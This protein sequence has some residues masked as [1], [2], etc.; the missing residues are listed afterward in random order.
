MAWLARLNADPLPWLLA[1]DTPAV[2][3]V[4]LRCLCDRTVD[5]GAVRAARAAAMTRD[6][7]KAILDAQ[8]SAGW[9]VKPGSGYAPKYRGTVWQ[10]IFLD[11]LGAD[12]DEE[13]VRRG[14]EYVLAH[15]IASS[16]GFASSGSKAEAAPS[17]LTVIHCLNGNLLA[18]LIGF[19][20]STTL[21][22]RAP[23]PGGRGRSPAR[24]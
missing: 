4:A 17:S 5:D 11:Q 19:G 24:G 3:A 21:G 9:W 15:S 14:C 6:P 23:W 10:I 2:R 22:C 8:D 1:E 18:A 16:G 20:T 13:R 7:V 12:P